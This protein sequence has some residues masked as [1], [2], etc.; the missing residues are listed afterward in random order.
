MGADI[1]VHV[2]VHVHMIVAKALCLGNC[3][4]I[5]ND[6]SSFS[7]WHDTIVNVSYLLQILMSMTIFFLILAVISN[8]LRFLAVKSLITKIKV[9]IR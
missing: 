1:H 9:I 8:W 5:D 4:Y 3:S 6:L 7:L 2:Y